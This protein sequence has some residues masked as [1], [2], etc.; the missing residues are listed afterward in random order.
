MLRFGLAVIAV[1]IAHAQNAQP[2]RLTSPEV[3][4]NGQVTFQL[5]APNASDVKLSGDWM[6][7]QPPSALTKSGDGVW[8]IRWA[9]VA[10]RVHL[11]IPG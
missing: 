10:Q 5:W 8:S 11:W 3:L 6:G 1:S 4:A 2:P 9:P 7:P